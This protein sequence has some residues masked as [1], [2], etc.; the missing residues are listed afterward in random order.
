MA[1][2]KRAAFIVVLDGCPTRALKLA[3]TPTIDEIAAQGAYTEICRSVCPTVTYTAHAS[4]VTGRWPAEHGLVGNVFYDRESGRLVDLDAEPPDERLRAPTLFERESALSLAV[5]EPITRGADLVIS[6]AQVQAHDLWEQDAFALRRAAELVRTRAPR[7]AVINLPGIDRV[8]ELYGPTSRELLEHLEEVDALLEEFTRVLDGV[9][10]DY[11]LILLADHGMVP[12]RENA[13]LAELLEGL[14]A[15]ICPSHRAAHIY[16]ADRAELG[17]ALERLRS[18]GRFELVLTREE[19]AEYGLDSPLSGDIFV[20]AKEG[21]EL[22]PEELRGSHGGVSQDEM[23]VFLIAN[24]PE[25]ADLLKDACITR[26]AEAVER[27]LRE[28]RAIERARELLARADPAHGW[29]HT[30][31]VL[32]LA[33]D[34]ALEHGADV[35][36]VRLAAIFH[37]VGRKAGEREPGEHAEGSARLAAAFLLAEGWPEERVELVRQAIL[38]HHAE[39]GKL[40]RL[41]ERILWEADKLDALGLVGLA[42]CLLE[43]G[44]RGEDIEEAVE[45]M[46][47][48][49][50]AFRASFSLPTAREKAAKR[51]AAALK[52]IRE[53]KDELEGRA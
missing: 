24:K 51:V 4:I 39:P 43:A 10:E 11:L 16:L 20:A 45:H 41:E 37:D 25:Y 36:A 23:M 13:D 49:L 40:R 47:R 6:K 35:E 26:A 7:L 50:E 27:Y 3:R 48:D 31:R 33:T 38:K 32:K 42:R 22:G 21:Y 29:E 18:D 17:E 44:S 53:L 12:V 8:G 14:E 2:G 15:V 1:K 30:E 5:G 9:Y 19:M 28:A 34:L 46:M 52:A